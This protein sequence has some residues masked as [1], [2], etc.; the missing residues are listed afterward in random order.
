MLG[1]AEQAKSMMAQITQFA[2]ETNFETPELADAS[3]SL[4]AFGV[5]QQQ[6][7][8]TMRMLGDISAGLNQPIGELA[9]LFGKAK[10]QGR[11]FAED[12]NQFQ[13][14]GIP[15][16]QQLAKNFGVAEGEIRGMVAEGKVGFPQLVAALAEMTAV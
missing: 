10:V 14:R 4:V 13:G 7:I 12:I 15:L 16:V 1:S 8:P 11:L 9:Q 5:A 2:A 3:K 6:V